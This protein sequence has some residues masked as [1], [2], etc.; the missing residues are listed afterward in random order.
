MIVTAQIM[1]PIPMFRFDWVAYL[2]EDPEDGPYAF[3][4]TEQEAI[5]ALKEELEELEELA[6]LS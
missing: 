3:G 4:E 2:E 6:G 1:P 5:E